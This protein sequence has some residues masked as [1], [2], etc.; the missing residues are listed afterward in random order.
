MKKRKRK[1]KNE[2]ISRK[3]AKMVC[4]W[5]W[6]T[7][8]FS[9]LIY[10]PCLVP[11]WGACRHCCRIC[12]VLPYYV[13]A[14]FFQ[15]ANQCQSNL[16]SVVVILFQSDLGLHLI[17]RPCCFLYSIKLQPVA[18]LTSTIAGTS[19]AI[20]PSC[21]P[22]QPTSRPAIHILLSWKY[23]LSFKPS[24]QQLVE[25]NKVRHLRIVWCSSIMIHTHEQCHSLLD[26][27]N[28]DPKV[29]IWSIADRDNRTSQKI[30]FDWGKN[31]IELH[32]TICPVTVGMT[33]ASF[34]THLPY[35][36]TIWSLDFQKNQR[37]NTIRSASSWLLN[38]RK[39]ICFTKKVHK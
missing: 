29:W 1:R 19:S 22:L 20:G 33:I 18:L 23:H 10:C 13:T 34:F 31:S 39:C 4:L 21:F 36:T 11:V 2:L 27:A 12:S 3:W 37:I 35:C 32:I 6:Y 15:A 38:E 30:L 7:F 25:W 5:F 9:V 16:T 14:N 17:C 28:L 8:A 24:N 26:V